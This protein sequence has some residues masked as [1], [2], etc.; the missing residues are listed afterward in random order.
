MNLHVV[1]VLQRVM[2]KCEL[3]ECDTNL[4]V[5]GTSL[6][7]EYVVEVLMLRILLLLRHF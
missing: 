3:L 4:L 1:S 6:A 7:L 5:R 2:Q